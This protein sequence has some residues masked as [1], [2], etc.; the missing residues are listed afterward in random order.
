MHFGMGF[1]R[2]DVEALSDNLPAACDNA[3]DA[4]IGAGGKTAFAGKG[5]G[6]LHMAAVG[7]GEGWLLGG[8][9]FRRPFGT[10]NGGGL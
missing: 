4:G 3:A 10:E 2:A 8:G 7:V 1:A 9:H 6:G 5:E